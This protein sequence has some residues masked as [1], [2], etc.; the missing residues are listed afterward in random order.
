MKRIVLACAGFAVEVA[1]IYQAQ[2]LAAALTGAGVVLVIALVPVFAE[3]RRGW[4]AASDFLREVSQPEPE[5]LPASRL[6]QVS[7]P[8][9]R[10]GHPP[11]DTA[12]QPVAVERP[13][14]DE[15]EAAGRH[16]ARRGLREAF[17][18]AI[19]AA[20]RVPLP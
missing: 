16:R 2:W 9:V 17:A 20:A 3:M 13:A 15:I 11:W 12:V 14:C 6:E 4:A 10:Q 5:R 7:V 8:R 19:K 1:L 18:D